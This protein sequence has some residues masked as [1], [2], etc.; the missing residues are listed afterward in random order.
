[1]LF[2]M[3]NAFKSLILCSLPLKV[4]FSV[5]GKVYVQQSLAPLKLV[6]AGAKPPA[7]A[8]QQ[9]HRCCIPTAGYESWDEKVDGKKNNGRN[10]HCSILT[11]E[12]LPAGMAHTGSQQLR[13]MKSA[14]HII[15]P[16]GL[17]AAL[18]VQALIFITH[19]SVTL[20]TRGE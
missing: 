11:E 4:F 13:E 15:P 2:L 1:M 17:G 20:E 8:R 18:A 16:K 14:F 19:S 7:A 12:P 9:R 5:K 10:D 6:R 3:T